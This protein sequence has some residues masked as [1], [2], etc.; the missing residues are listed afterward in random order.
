[1]AGKQCNILS[2]ITFCG[3]SNR[4]QGV[5]QWVMNRISGD[6]HAVKGYASKR[7]VRSAMLECDISNHVNQ[8]RDPSTTSTIIMCVTMISLFLHMVPYD[9]SSS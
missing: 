2:T 3:A 5:T 4:H 7:S 1:M 8:T 6:G 9:L